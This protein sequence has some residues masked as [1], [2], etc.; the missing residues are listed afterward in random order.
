ME[1]GIAHLCGISRGFVHLSFTWRVFQHGN[2]FNS[3]TSSK[4]RWSIENALSSTRRHEKTPFE[5][6][7][8]WPKKCTAFEASIP[9]WQLMPG[10]KKIGGCRHILSNIHMLLAQFFLTFEIAWIGT[11]Q[12]G[13]LHFGGCNWYNTVMI[14]FFTY[15]DCSSTVWIANAYEIWL[16]GTSWPRNIPCSN[17]MQNH[18][19]Q[20]PGLVPA[21][22]FQ[23]HIYAHT[24]VL[25]Y[26]YMY[27]YIYIC[28]ETENSLKSP[29]KINGKQP[30]KRFGL[31]S[32]RREKA[33]LPWCAPQW[34]PPSYASR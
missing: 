1:M 13:Q 24:Y 29:K 18:W 6:E 22:S 5:N 30:T 31:F 33:P 32:K 16:R 21:I 8:S 11:H 4:L 2:A 28:R 15:T 27:T 7:N 20:I 12:N 10:S 17:D 3:Y 19:S 34:G 14:R 25:I 23:V 9:T 26:I